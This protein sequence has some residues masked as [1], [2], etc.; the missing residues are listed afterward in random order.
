MCMYDI[1][2]DDLSFSSC[3]SQDPK[4][5]EQRVILIQSLVKG[6]AAD[7]DGRLRVED[8]LLHVNHTA[9]HGEMLDFTVN[10]LTSIPLGSSAVIG[11]NHPLP[12]TPEDVDWAMSPESA[13]SMGE[14]EEEEGEEEGEEDEEDDFGGFSEQS[15]VVGGNEPHQLQDVSLE[16]KLEGIRKEVDK[17]QQ[18]HAVVTFHDAVILVCLFWGG[19]GD[20][21]ISGFK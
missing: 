4:N 13:T 14:G 16:E 17:Q 21:T 12:N 3:S 11:V 8:K 7:V 15:T 5:K 10:L 19:R 1:M 9:V 18:Q 2:Y 20:D 6:G